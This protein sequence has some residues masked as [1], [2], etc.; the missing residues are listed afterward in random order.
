MRNVVISFTLR[1]RGQNYDLLHA[2]I[3]AC[4][5]KL[6]QRDVSEYLIVTSFHDSSLKLLLGF[7]LDANDTLN[8]YSVVSD[9]GINQEISWQ[10]GGLGTLEGR[11]LIQ[12]VQQ[13]ALKIRRA[14]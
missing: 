5:E 6:I 9:T 3:W 11:K 1:P 10:Q 4:S 14:S 12:Q 7:A 8:I 13:E 2:L